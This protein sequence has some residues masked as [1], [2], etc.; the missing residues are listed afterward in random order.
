MQVSKT[1]FSAHGCQ[2][3]SLSDIIAAAGITKGAFYHYFKS[4]ENL[5][6]AVVE[7]LLQEYLNIV[8]SLNHNLQP[9]EK[10]RQLL[11][12][13]AQL[14][15]SGEWVNCRL[16]LRLTAECDEHNPQLQSRIK[17]FWKW[18]IGLFEDLISQCRA[19][20]QIKTDI[21]PK[22]QVHLILDIMA[23]AMVLQNA[24]PA[25]PPFTQIVEIII[26]CL[27]S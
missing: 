15:T 3:T 10:L 24:E 4:K 7:Q 11:D 12:T 26:N 1:L 25:S 20:G 13:I 2:N 14:N 18:Y 6:E 9:I 27:R 19:A 17:D 23:G 8:N 22:I 16:I 21:S 5:C